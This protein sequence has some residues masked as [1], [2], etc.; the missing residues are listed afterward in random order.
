MP[1]YNLFWFSRQKK[2]KKI[3]VAGK[4]DL[5]VVGSLLALVE[6][7]PLKRLV[8]LIGFG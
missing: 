2:K 5:S 1:A 3:Y 8:H 4:E 7:S 6:V